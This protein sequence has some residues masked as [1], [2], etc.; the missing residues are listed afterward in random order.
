[1]LLTT[2]HSVLNQQEMCGYDLGRDMVTMRYMPQ[3]LMHKHI[4]FSFWT[5]CLPSKV[6]LVQN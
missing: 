3:G 1:M 5:G 6:S 2:S 4:A